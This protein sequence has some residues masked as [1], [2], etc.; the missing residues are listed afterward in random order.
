MKK[1]FSLSTTILFS[2]LLASQAQA[3]VP[4][5]QHFQQPTTIS[6][7]PATLP[8]PFAT[9][10][11]T[12][13]PTIIPQPA[14]ASFTVPV[15]FTVNL[16]ADSTASADVTLVTPRV[17]LLAP[18]GDILLADP[19]SNT[20]VVLRDS[21]K[22]GSA[23]QAFVFTS[24]TL[25]PFG[26][27]FWQDYLYVGNTDSIVRF[28]YT[29]GQTKAAGPPEVIVANLTQKGGGHFTRNIVFSPDQKTL[30]IAIG[31]SG[32]VLV[33]ADPRRATVCTCNP[34][35]SNFQIFA[36][37]IRNPVG[38]TINPVTSA[39]WVATNERDS[40]GDN[41]VPDYVTS[42]QQGGFY[43]WPYTYIG[44]NPDPRIPQD[45]PDLIN[46]AIIPDVLLQSHSAPLGIL[47]Y[48]GS[49]FPAE[50]QGDAFVTSHGSWNRLVSTGYKII[51]IRFKN[52]KPVANQY[53]DFLTG[54]LPAPE[55]NQAWGRPV[56]VTQYWD[57][58]LLI[59]DDG[60]RKIWRVSYC[61]LYC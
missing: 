61:G 25:A 55:L 44:K 47:F 56:G 28:K 53:E 59:S 17:M 26:L 38:L 50:Y 13:F 43:G 36:T 51:R 60:G 10:S 33:E 32:N 14:N 21:K 45:R 18:N 48:G 39:V 4:A 27:A 30:Y 42:V 5:I 35:G 58:S 19:G 12:A 6:V 1:V 31:S 20:I 46:R 9:N 15:G 40:L 37:G 57:G 8:A 11:S 3:V 22:A 2:L 24:D 29:V 49:S 16:F 23:D 52:G 54:W 41:L 34:D 7:D